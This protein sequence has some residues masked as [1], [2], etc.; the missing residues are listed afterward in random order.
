VGGAANMTLETRAAFRLG[1]LGLAL[2]MTCVRPL[3]AQDDLPEG[4]GRETLENTCTECHGLDKA[5]SQLRTER[6]WRA[7]ALQM[8]SKG[9]TMNDE[10][11]K[12]LVA[13]L[14][15]NF[16]S[17]EEDE[18]KSGARKVDV[19]RASVE[20]IESVL[21]LR[22]ADAAAIV[23][24]REAKGRFRSWR[25]VAKVDGV[26]KSRIEAVKDRIVF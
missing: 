24:H 10:E 20:E 23:R 6:Q 19:N 12:T 25:D 13:Y 21:H 14:S 26:D 5:L 11:L 18:A 22:P 15:Q 9:A 2:L 3:R 8:R 17:I 1:L 4:K 16:G 7:I